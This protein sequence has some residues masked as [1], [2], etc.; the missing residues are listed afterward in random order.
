ME[1]KVSIDC[2]R[3]HSLFSFQGVIQNELYYRT[4]RFTWDATANGTSGV[5]F[6]RVAFLLHAPHRYSTTLV[7][8]TMT[9]C[10]PL[11][12]VEGVNNG[13]PIH[14]EISTVHLLF[15]YDRSLLNRSP[16]LWALCRI[17]KN[18]N[19]RESAREEDDREGEE[20]NE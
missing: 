17:K 3:E 18:Q 20:Q 7:T 16:S 14:K 2:E 5:R 19:Q 8:I 4:T 6:R 12:S 11:Y 15:P 10:P 9:F 1:A 13:P